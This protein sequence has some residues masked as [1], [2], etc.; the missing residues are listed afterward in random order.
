MFIVRL[1]WKVVIYYKIN[2][3]FSLVLINFD[4]K[5][6]EMRRCYYS[7]ISLFLVRFDIRFRLVEFGVFGLSFLE[8][9]F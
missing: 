9:T 1:K 4:Y 2:Y 7:M 5:M 3:D 6:E 8:S